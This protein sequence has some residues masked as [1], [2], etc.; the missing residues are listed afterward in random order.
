MHAEF[1]K[2]ALERSTRCLREPTLLPGNYT[3]NKAKEPPIGSMG[4]QKRNAGILSPLLSG[5]SE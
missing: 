1:A 2:E 5:D 3:P 4:R